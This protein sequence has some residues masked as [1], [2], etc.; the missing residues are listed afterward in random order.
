MPS[1]PERQVDLG[2]STPSGP[3]R[4]IAGF[5]LTISTARRD[6]GLGNRIG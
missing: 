3:E 6:I 5:I 1:R 2:K 4:P